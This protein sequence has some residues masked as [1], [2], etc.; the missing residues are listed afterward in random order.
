[1]LHEPQRR[2][3]KQWPCAC[4]DSK[5]WYPSLAIF[6][7]PFTTPTWALRYPEG[8]IHRVGTWRCLKYQPYRAGKGQQPEQE[9]LRSKVAPSCK[10]PK[11]CLIDRAT[12]RC[13]R[14]KGLQ[15]K[16][17]I[18]ELSHQEHKG[19]SSGPTPTCRNEFFPVH[20]A[21]GTITILMSS[22]RA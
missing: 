12:C 13:Q 22:C 9:Q 2:P 15:V 17:H 21:A 6:R 4:I 5:S 11:K 14:R 20:R 16:A 18:E 7:K 8:K 10:L 1:M 19:L 3:L